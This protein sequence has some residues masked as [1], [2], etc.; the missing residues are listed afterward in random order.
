MALF[1]GLSFVSCDKDDNG[2]EKINSDNLFAGTWVKDDTGAVVVFTESTWTATYQGSLYNSGTYTYDGNTAIWKITNKGT[3]SANVGDTGSATISNNK[4]T[5]SSF[6]DTVMNGQYTKQANP[7]DDEDNV[8]DWVLINGVKW[9]TRNV[10]DPGSFVANPEDYGGYYQWNKGTTDFLLHDNYSNSSYPKST[11]WRPAN[12]PSPAGYRVPTL[13]ELESL[14]KSPYV[15]YE[16]TPQNGVWG[17]KFT[18]YASG[19]SIFLPAAGY[20]HL[21]D[22]TLCNVG[23][24]SYYWS[25]TQYGSVDSYAY[26]LDFN[27]GVSQVASIYKSYGF[28]VRPV[29]N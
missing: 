9:A 20:R 23:Y 21:N 25:S 22:A 3:G 15:K 10:G 7:K 17:G 29:A 12:D 27:D 11:T 2:G 14:I 28:P 4:M 26:Y 19:K 24:F 5:V 16:W 6:S 1:V 8:D 18:D 13:A